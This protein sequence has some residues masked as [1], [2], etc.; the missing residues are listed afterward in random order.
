MFVDDSDDERD[1]FDVERR[2]IEIF[3]RKFL[4]TT[5]QSS[6]SSDD[7]DEG[8][9][10]GTKIPSSSKA[11]RRAKHSF[12]DISICSSTNS[13]DDEIEMNPFEILPVTTK[14]TIRKPTKNEIIETER[15]MQQLSRCTKFYVENEISTFVF[16]QLNNSSCR[17]SSRNLCKIF[18]N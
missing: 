15:K 1:S 3:Q 13:N 16:L 5:F 8:I 9:I 11:K 10:D 7:D 17:H 14:P 2:Q 6:S 18:N 12:L 4:S